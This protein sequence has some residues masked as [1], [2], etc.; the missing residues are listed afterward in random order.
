MKLQTNKDIHRFFMNILVVLI[1]LLLSGLILSQVIV[2]DLKA[3]VMEHNSE[4][5]GYLLE[6]GVD[7]ADITA[8][9]SSTKTQQEVSVGQKYLQQ[10]GYQTFEN[11]S[12]LS[13]VNGVLIKYQII[14]LISIAIFGVLFIGAFFRYFKRQQSDIDNAIATIGAFMEGNTA[15]RLE[16]EEEGSLSK[17]FASINIMA[18]SLN[19]HIET[20]KR[21]KDFLKRTIAD[22]SHQLK[23]PLAAIKMCNDIMQAESDNEISVKRF[24]TKSAMALEQMEIL[25]QNLLKITKFDAGTITLNKENQNV[26]E[27]LQDTVLGFEMRIN[28]E[29]KS[30]T[31][32][33][34]E[35]TVISCDKDWIKEA[36]GNLIKNALDHMEPGSQV[37]ITWK[38]TPAITK[39]IVQDNGKGIDPEDIHH[40]FKRFY[41][42]RFSQDKQ[43][44]GLGLSLTKSIVEAHNGTITVNSTLGKGSTF[45]LDFLKL[46]NL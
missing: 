45:T 21:T 8:A 7:P 10:I 11:N 32:D 28:Q 40:V 44:V 30:I 19:A 24:S 27:L 34:A 39:I 46:T 18:T 15:V 36:V 42:S 5:A 4:V 41:R 22:I 2:H 29:H 9:F 3:Q 43:G 35:D 26:Y 20:E 12:S 14:F 1:L 6:R 17:L 37:N 31:L 33:G 38:E 23:T 16:S 13:N 25:I